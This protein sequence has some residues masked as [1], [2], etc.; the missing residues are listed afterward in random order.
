MKKIFPASLA[1]TF[2]AAIVLIPL[3]ISVDGGFSHPE[4]N[5]FLQIYTDNTRPLLNILFDPQLTDWNHYQARELSYFFDWI[6]ANFILFCCS[7]GKAHF[8]SIVT[9]LLLLGTVF[10]AMRHTDSI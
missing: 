10:S 9:I 7:I 6:D 3:L 8:Y 5:A 2:L 4:S 1:T